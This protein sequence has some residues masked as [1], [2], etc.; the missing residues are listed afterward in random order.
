M[1]GCFAAGG[2]I[3]HRL[4]QLPSMGE[5]VRHLWS[6]VIFRPALLRVTFLNRI[7]LIVLVMFGLCEPVFAQD[8]ANDSAPPAEAVQVVSAPVESAVTTAQKVLVT[9]RIRDLSNGKLD[10]NTN[11]ETLFAVSPEDTGEFGF[12]ALMRAIDAPKFKTS[13]PKEETEE[14]RIDRELFEAR[15]AFLR[16]PTAKRDALLEAHRLK[17][18]A[19]QTQI[20]ARISE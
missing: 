5:N 12:D 14:H 3:F 11:A 9:S 17:R 6:C 15:V 18:V 4:L 2:P 19:Y 8:E 1:L 20:N 10:P 7:F 16:L 13:K